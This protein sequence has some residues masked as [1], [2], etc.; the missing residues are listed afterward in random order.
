MVPIHRRKLVVQK[1]QQGKLFE[2]PKSPLTKEGFT[3]SLKAVGPRTLAN[4]RSPFGIASLIAGAG[5]LDYLTSERGE[6]KQK[7]DDLIYQLGRGARE[8]KAE[9][10][11]ASETGPAIPGSDLELRRKAD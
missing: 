11:I 4:L 8:K 2:I 10:F 1:A 9:A 7:R 3:Q 6:L 5:G